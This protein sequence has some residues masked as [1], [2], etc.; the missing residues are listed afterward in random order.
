VTAPK[1]KKEMP[2]GESGIRKHRRKG[3][4]LIQLDDLIPKGKNVL[5]G[6]RHLFGA[7]EINQTSNKPK[8]T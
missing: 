1:E 8:K 2:A 5:G 3:G 6:G 4:K 7:S